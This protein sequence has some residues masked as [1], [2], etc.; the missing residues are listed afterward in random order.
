M[1]N[2]SLYYPTIEFQDYTWLWSASLLWDRIYRIIPEGYEPDEPENIR[3]LLETGE[4]GIPIR[5]DAYTKET[6][7]DFLDKVDSGQ[8]SAAALEFE[9]PEAYA[10]LHQDKVDVE[11][12]NMIIAKGKADAHGEWLNVPIE[13]ETLYM[14]YLANQVAQ[15]NNLQL[16]S[17]SAAAWTGATFFKYDGEIEPFPYEDQTQQLATLVVRD[18][19]PGNI[20]D[21]HPEAILKFRA[22]YGDERR[23]FLNSIR[24]AAKAFSECEDEGIYRDRFEDLKREIEASLKDYRGSLQALNVAAWTGI[25]SVSFPVVTKVATAIAGTDLDVATLTVVSALG[26]GLGLV[27]GFSDWKEKRRKIDKDS[28]YSYL[29]HLGRNWKGSAM[30]KN[31]YN[32]FL[33]REMEEF[34]ND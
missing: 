23:R 2:Y 16:V 4:I 12:R 1:P 8:W 15:R 9:I 31:D 26:I 6:A 11:L 10:R 18:F 7:K 28:D 13:F 27:S 3:L 17:D 19:I 25:K 20:M 32:Y 14:T 5:P 34:I 21:F 24:N 30:Y 33:C 22:K 29:M